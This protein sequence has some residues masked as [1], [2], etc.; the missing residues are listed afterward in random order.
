VITCCNISPAGADTWLSVSFKI[1]IARSFSEG[2]AITTGLPADL[3]VDHKHLESTIHACTC[4]S[5][6]LA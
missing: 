4:A 6:L 3:K 1:S 2:M 5:M